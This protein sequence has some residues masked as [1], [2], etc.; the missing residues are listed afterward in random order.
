MKS[1]PASFRIVIP[2]ARSANLIPCVHA[3]LAREPE[4]NP[5]DIV[6]IDDGARAETEARIPGLTWLDGF[7]PF[8][9][10]RNVNLGLFAARPSDVLLLNDDARLLTRYGFTDLSRQARTHP[11]VG[12][13]SAGIDGL[14]CN[15]TQE[16]RDV[17]AWREV[18]PEMAFICV[19]LTRTLIDSIGFL[20]ERFTGYGF[21]DFDYARRAQA[22]GF[23]LGVWDGCVV[24]HRELPSTYRTRHDFFDL[25]DVNRDL[26]RRKWAQGISLQF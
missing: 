3:I 24:E 10:A 11:G 21:E 4:I 1:N 8:V 22:A 20:D 25:S 14:V 12:I 26:Y 9:F 6:I 2:S 7:R 5:A 15:T 16:A 19:Y 17:P 23:G 18:S 13:C